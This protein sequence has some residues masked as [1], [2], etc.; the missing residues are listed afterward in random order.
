M[1]FQWV[2]MVVAVVAAAVLTMGAAHGT[3][4]RFCGSASYGSGCPYSA[5]GRHQHRGVGDACEFCGSSSYGSGCPY[6]TTGR[7]KHGGDGARCIWCGSSSYGSGCPYSA[8]GR[9][10]R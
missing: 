10:E 3:H 8:T 1:K 4:C 6:S 7:H 9:H 5:T 2:T